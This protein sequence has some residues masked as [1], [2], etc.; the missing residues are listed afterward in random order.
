VG[1]A[2]I[3][4]G[5]FGV[6]DMSNEESHGRRL[7]VGTL[8]QLGAT[9]VSVVSSLVVATA[10]GRTL[11]LA[12]FG[13]YGLTLSIAGYLS[14]V[15]GSVESAGVLQ[16][17]KARNADE[18]DRA[19]TS[20]VLAY[21]TAGLLTGLV[22]AIG[23]LALL[24]VFDIPGELQGQARLGIIALG[25]INAV[26][27]PP[28]AYRDILLATQRYK[29]A[30]ATLAG[31][32]LAFLATMLP[33]VLV[34][35][36]PLW[37]LIATGG[38]LPAGVG[39]V[40]GVVAL[41]LRL[42]YRF[43]PSLVDRAYLRRFASFGGGVFAIAITD[44]VIFQLDRTVLALFRSPATI[45]LYEAAVRPSN[46][47]RQLQGSLS[48]TVFPATANLM[49]DED[50]H[51]T[52]ELVVRGIKYVTAVV[53]PVSAV[54]CVLSAPII[55]VWLG[56][57]FA[58]AAPAMSILVGTWIFGSTIAILSTMVIVH[59]RV[60]AMAVWSWA[61]AGLN[62]ALSLSLTPVLG[63]NGV[64]IG[65][66]GSYALMTP[67]LVALAVRV[68][69]VTVAELA[70]RAWIP[71]LAPAAALAAAL[72]VV[73]SVVDLDSLVP[74][75]LVVGLAFAVYALVYAGF[76]LD[77]SE[78]ALFRGLIPRAREPATVS[79]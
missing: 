78:R 63:L 43:R 18:R 55:D 6:G 36:P 64:V 73:N 49:A 9:L 65:T 22:L 51:R 10:L 44:I 34:V 8:A 48:Y 39:I 58:D 54:F 31:G 72:L 57:R 27:W 45:G 29:L 41:F 19:F 20:A 68:L 7:A 12:E 15:L 26:G 79:R 77:A 38:F 40:S 50:E 67:V 42:P 23:G 47:V 61:L 74:L 59:G 4:I 25:A 28:R 11:S 53:M 70:R 60:R 66:T 71:A 1:R 35:K 52:R 62:L 33:L 21:G 37:V 5:L 46:F 69:P 16:I 56:P 30:A 75:L 24:G 14:F 13:V 3:A 32:Y 76:F 2:P 17:S